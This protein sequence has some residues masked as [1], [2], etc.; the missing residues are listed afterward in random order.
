M[1][2]DDEDKKKK[3][4]PEMKDPG[5]KGGNKYSKDTKIV[6][7]TEENQ[8]RIS[9][10]EK[11][12]R[13]LMEAGYTDKQAGAKAKKELRE[14][15]KVQK[16]ADKIEQKE[17]I[18]EQS[19]ELGLTQDQQKEKLIKPEGLEIQTEEAKIEGQP[20]Q[21]QE[22]GFLNRF[23]RGVSGQ[24]AKEEGV[25]TGTLPIGTAGAAGAGAIASPAK[26]V[27]VGNSLKNSK[28]VQGI[29]KDP[30]KWGVAAYAGAQSIEGFV[31]WISKKE[32]INN[33]QQALNTIGQMATTIGGQ[34][35]EG[36]G[37]WRKGLNELRYIREEVERLG[38]LMQQGKIKSA[39]LRW[40]GQI[41]DIEAD[42]EDQLRTIDEQVTI[43][44]S[45]ALSGA[46]PE[47]SDYE[48]QNYLRELEQE[49][50]IEPVDL[51]KARQRGE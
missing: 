44:E 32:K 4:K 25:L 47:L 2:K 22:E 24:A 8:A 48:L 15:S 17:K 35:T 16:E 37:D 31:D 36:A 12:K 14:G 21:E 13:E 26:A 41:Y 23:W 18:L 42:I 33:Q 30:L 46:I 38:A 28:I 5:K 9:K 40:N 34:A 50:Y 51:T 7:T 10:R 43:V 1:A 20:A 11:R 3:K 39:S 19:K 49:G 29:L 27:K 6:R 45:F